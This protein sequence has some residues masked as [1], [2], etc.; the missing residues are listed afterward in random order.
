[1]KINSRQKGARG[2]REARDLLRRFGFKAERGQQNAGGVDSPDIKHNV[3]GWHFEV[4]RVERL[5]LSVAMAQAERDAGGV[6]KPCVLHKRNGEPW[7]VTIKAED[8]L[9]LLGGMDF[10]DL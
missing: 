5:N 8:F 6:N 1:M 7:L 3:P 2:E 9:A 10:S 4:K